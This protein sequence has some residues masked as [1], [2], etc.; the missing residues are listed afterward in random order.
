MSIIQVNLSQKPSFLHQLTHNMTQDCSLNSPKSS[1]EHV[2]YKKCFFCLD[3]QNNICSQHVLNLC[4]SCNSMNN[5]SS[6]CGLPDA[7]MRASEKDLLVWWTIWVNLIF[8]I[9]TWGVCSATDLDPWLLIRFSWRS[10]LSEEE[11]NTQ[12]KYRLSE[13]LATTSQLTWIFS[14]F[15]TP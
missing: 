14:R 2:V 1:A 10:N 9:L 11:L 3:I 8:S 5:F 15:A 12:L 6:Y 7:R 13:G 4:F